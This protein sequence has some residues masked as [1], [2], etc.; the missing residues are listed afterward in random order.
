MFSQY[1]MKL[2]WKCVRKKCPTV[3]PCGCGYLKKLKGEYWHSNKCL[4][5][6]AQWSQSW[7][8]AV[9]LKYG[10]LEELKYVNEIGL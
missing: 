7:K 6:G 1:W 5:V 2:G 3:L 10:N 8:F 9:Q 4:N